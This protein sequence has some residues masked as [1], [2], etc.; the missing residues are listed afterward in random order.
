[1]TVAR[2][3]LTGAEVVAALLVATALLVAAALLIVAAFDVVTALVEVGASTSFSADAEPRFA[4][5]ALALTW[6]ATLLTS[7]G[8]TSFVIPLMKDID[9]PPASFPDAESTLFSRHERPSADEQAEPAFTINVLTLAPL[10][11][12][13]CE[14]PENTLPSMSAW[15][16][17]YASKAWPFMFSK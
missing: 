6:A 7:R 10:S 1:L 4:G 8:E 5:P 15:A 3:V 9:E 13:G 12:T 11:V 2:V 14:T 17:V 16:P